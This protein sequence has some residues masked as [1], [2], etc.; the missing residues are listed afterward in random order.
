MSS[1]GTEAGGSRGPR[2]FVTAPPSLAEIAEHFPELEILELIGAG[3]MG[4]VYKVRQPKLDRVLALKILSLE[5]AG[6]Q[7]FAERFEREAKLLA[8]LH[9]PGV[10][11]IFDSGRA[12]P[13]FHFLIEFVDGVNLRE[14]MATG[15][16][17]PAYALE[18][19]G[20][21]CEALAFAHGRG[22]LHRD[23]KPENIL[24]GSDGGVK[25]AD[26]G[27]AKLGGETELSNAT[28][29]RAGS[30]LGSVHYMA[31]EQF[32]SP[33]NVDQRADIYSVG[34]V[35]YEM[36]T[37]ELPMGRFAP[38]SKGAAVNAQVDAVVLRAL[39]RD[40]AARFQTAEE[41][42]AVL[43]ETLSVPNT[44]EPLPAPAL[45]P[46]NSLLRKF[47]HPRL[48]ALLHLGLGL[49]GLGFAVR[50]MLLIPMKGG[51][52]PVVTFVREGTRTTT[53]TMMGVS[54]DEVGLLMLLGKFIVGFTGLIFGWRLFRGQKWGT[55]GVLLTSVWRLGEFPVGTCAAL[56]SFWV[57]LRRS[58][59]G[60]VAARCASGVDEGRVGV[61]CVELESARG[62]HDV[63][64][65]AR[66]A[67]ISRCVGHAN[68][69]GSQTIGAERHREGHAA[70]RDR[71]AI[72][73][74]RAD[75]RAGR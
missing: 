16:F 66:R 14:A 1:A 70:V 37:G 45:A 62:Q 34:V 39:E 53:Q 2:H 44:S 28:L 59:E 68:L 40:R 52:L 4:A 5:L 25:L 22:V 9:H 55:A 54:V 73:L 67:D 64:G 24:I 47:D 30:I 42:R 15:R 27:I 21:V 49:A 60:E 41:M 33:G 57:L 50:A 74:G 38:P 13:F 58:P 36:L 46:S 35:L 51:E 72:Q 20:R 43:A 8:R 65:D 7:G 56:Y 48:V 71:S 69:D 11:T 19:A 61:R 63:D 6:E 10:V 32:V 18:V 75:E 3:G 12:G 26:F 23:I 29:T 31:P 17:E